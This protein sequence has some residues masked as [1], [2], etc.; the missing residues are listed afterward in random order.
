M[1]DAPSPLKVGVMSFAHT[2]AGGYVAHLLA[3]PDV[4]VKASDPAHGTAVP[5]EVRGRELADQLGVDHV[6][7]YE[8]LLAWGPDAVV[9]CSENARHR[10]AVELAAAAGAHV[11]CEKPLA[12]ETEDATAMIAACERAGV[13]LMTAFP[14]R[15]SP[16]FTALRAGVEAGQLGE[17]AAA[18]GTNNGKIPVG[19][20]SWFT[21]P[22]LSGGGAI[23]D[24]TV[25]V[26]D[27]LDAL[28]GARAETVHCVS[29][30]ILHADKPEV[31][32]ETAGLV[33]ITYDNGVIATI[34]CS[35]S[36]PDSAPTWGGVTLEV[37][38]T[39][40]SA[41]ID[42]FAQHVGGL[43]ESAGRA[44]WIPFGIDTDALMLSEFLDAI[45]TG[46]RPQPDGQA[47]LR[48]LQI[49]QAAQRSAAS[50]SPVTI[51]AAE[52]LPGDI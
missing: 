38:G 48:T 46:R 52:S 3:R 13:V 20:R 15:F 28:L 30:R 42:P 10:E 26:A 25:H 34:D 21:D 24:H 9:V 39:K 2:H 49:V 51:R 16:M 32:A 8:E 19:A 47:G 33:T 45:R 29:N 40:G 37:V 31:R 50:G 11:L 27:L 43:D 35:W 1:S 23:V 36:V 41:A 5:G 12:T 7:T 6:D 17:I 4:E 22:A 44:V 14:V 18:T